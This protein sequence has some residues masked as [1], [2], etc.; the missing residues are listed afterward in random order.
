MF[1]VTTM[2]KWS[3]PIL[4]MAIFVVLLFAC[5][6]YVQANVTQIDSVTHDMWSW[7]C[8]NSAYQPPPAKCRSG[9]PDD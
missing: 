8:E 5:Q 7:E 6:W 2:R 9:R 4:L 3:G 1:L